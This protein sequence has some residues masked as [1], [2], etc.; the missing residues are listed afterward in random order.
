LLKA[1]EKEVDPL[2]R[3]VILTFESATQIPTGLQKRWPS[4]APMI[5]NP[6]LES[7]EYL[8]EE[9][10][11]AKTWIREVRARWINGEHAIVWCATHSRTPRAPVICPLERHK[12]DLT[13]AAEAVG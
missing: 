7:I 1:A 11:I 2:D 3:S 6:T 8:E 10:A 5:S 13:P 9:Q 4:E 12:L